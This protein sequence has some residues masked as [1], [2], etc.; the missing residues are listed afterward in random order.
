MGAGA[1]GVAG[2]GKGVEIE[3][4]RDAEDD[5]E[6][7]A[8]EGIERDVNEASEPTWRG[9]TPERGG[10]V[11]KGAAMGADEEGAAC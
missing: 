6:G 1:S 11:P 2:F 4:E 5:E 9:G 7:V 3:R 8:R 10:I